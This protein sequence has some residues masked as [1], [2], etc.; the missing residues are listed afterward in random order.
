M[1]TASMERR[2]RRDVAGR[3]GQA[4]IPEHG[5]VRSDPGVFER[6]REREREQHPARARARPHAGHDE[7]ESITSAACLSLPPGPTP[8][9]PVTHVRPGHTCI[10]PSS[11]P[12]PS[13]RLLLR[14]W[15]GLPRG[16]QG[17]EIDDQE[18]ESESESVSLD[19]VR[20][21]VPRRRLTRRDAPRLHL[22]LHL[23]A[24]A[25][26][27]AADHA[28][29][30][31]LCSDPARCEGPECCCHACSCVCVCGGGGGGCA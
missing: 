26:A 14:G 23:H 21:R 8:P 29:A 24:H 18:T 3:E 13:R 25:H 27:H 12:G 30:C 9:A 5:C 15:P 31:S 19:G 2:R 6:A 16:R 7:E 4:D 20:P 17:G 1:L 22:H 28:G 11:R 10:L